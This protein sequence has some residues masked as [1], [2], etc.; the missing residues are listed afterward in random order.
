MK[1]SA[2]LLIALGLAP[3]L[4]CSQ[5]VPQVRSMLRDTAAESTAA[6][7]VHYVGVGIG[8]W[9]NGD[10][11]AQINAAYAALPG[12]GG[13]IVVVAPPNGE[14]YSFSTPIV[15][16]LAGKYLLLEG[17]AMA[18][19]ITRAAAPACLNFVPTNALAAI[20]LDYI[21][22]G[23]TSGIA[24]HGIQN[25]TLIN[26]QCESIG[27]CNSAATGI[28]FGANGGAT[29]GAFAG[30]K[31][32]GFGTGLALSSSNSRGGSLAVR[33]CSISY[34]TTGFLATDADGGQ[35]SFDSCHFHGNATAVSSTSSLR[36]SNSWMESNTVVGVNCSAPAACDINSDH[37][38]NAEADTTHFLAGN[39]VFSVLGGD[40]RDNQTSGKTDWWMNFAGASFFLLGTTLTSSGRVADHVISTRTNGV[41]RV[42]NNTPTL[43]TG[44]QAR[45]PT[46][47][48]SAI[49]SVQVS[50]MTEKLISELRNQMRIKDISDPIDG[51]VVGRG[52]VGPIPEASI[53]RPVLAYEPSQVTTPAQSGAANNV[54]HVGQD[55]AESKGSDIG[56]KINSAY[57]ALPRSGGSIIVDPRADGSCYSYETPI[58]LATAG[59]YVRLEAFGASGATGATS[60]GGVCLNFLPTKG[61]AITL[62]YVTNT[63][64]PL[65]AAHGLR[66]ITLINN[67]CFSTGGCGSSAVGISTGLHN[68]GTYG[69]SMEN[70]AVTGF[71]V[72]YVNGNNSSVQ[73]AWYNPQF[74]CNTVAVRLNSITGFWIFGGQMAG[75]GAGLTA[76]GPA[77]SP[78]MILYGLS[79]FG[80][81]GLAVDFSRSK[82]VSIL[83]CF[84]CHFENSPSSGNARFIAGPIDI[85]LSGGV[86]ESDVPNT[87]FDWMIS[88]YGNRLIID[89]MRFFTGVGSTIE[90]IIVASNPVRGILRGF[91]NSAGHFKRYVGGANAHNFTIE[92]LAGNGRVETT[93]FSYESQLQAPSLMINGG[94][95]LA[96]SNQSGKG[97]LCMT[98]SCV[99]QSPR[100]EGPTIAGGDIKDVTLRAPMLVS[101]KFADSLQEPALIRPT[102]GG[103][104]IISKILLGSTM[105]TFPPISAS[106]CQEESLRLAGASNKGVSSASP[107]GDLG[108]KNLSWQSRISALNVVTVRVCN[109][110]PVAITPHS[111]EW[112]VSVIQ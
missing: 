23:E 7:N 28:S 54:I 83:D 22:R 107:T 82:S 108:N 104:S 48:I 92:M 26:N 72:G 37:F 31:V 101:P 5:T 65:S 43:L 56:A 47:E 106:S 46:D 90:Q 74:F 66:N 96:T 12:T 100:I 77:S 52:T 95:P 32:I 99:M 57:A 55:T 20:T 78:E 41:V 1:S 84:A 29:G 85:Y 39:G 11:G 42:Q 80:N 8:G 10:I 62:D 75:N 63:Q 30:L 34:N 69:A 88:A 89:G 33:D 97:E 60:M 111:V 16:A 4:T 9:G 73:I 51:H 36:I 13:T 3:I 25:L 35:V 109:T 6:S 44:I 86:M 67:N 110:N 102:I 68:A 15:A 38:E 93:P 50:D 61:A 81:T 71:G 27:G 103:G 94:N 19:Q 53:S 58:S 112:E 21:P 64:S 70:V 91:V 45:R 24:T 18:S 59:K 79:I 40:M 105:L 87:S 17:G 14:C 76:F 49:S 2:I 98:I